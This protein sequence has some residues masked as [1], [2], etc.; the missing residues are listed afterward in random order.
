MILHREDGRPG[1]ENIETSKNRT[2]LLAYLTGLCACTSNQIARKYLKHYLTGQ[3]SKRNG[4]ML[5]SSTRE[6]KCRL[7]AIF[8]ER[9]F[10]MQML[11]E[12]HDSRKSTNLHKIC[13]MP[14]FKTKDRT[15]KNNK[16][17]KLV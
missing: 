12:L 3:N 14:K 4:N 7:N 13:Q 10:S 2:Q 5:W 6:R 8:T 15:H 16:L 1:L 9:H 11:Q 17:N